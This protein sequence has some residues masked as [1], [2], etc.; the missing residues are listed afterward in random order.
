M[1]TIYALIAIISGL[2]RGRENILELHNVVI[3]E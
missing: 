3:A 2:I 1:C